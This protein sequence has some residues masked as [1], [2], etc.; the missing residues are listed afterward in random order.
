VLPDVNVWLA[1][2]FQVHAHHRAAVEWF[3]EADA[4]SCHWCRLTQQGFLRLATN[5]SVFGDEA[6]TLM[7]AWSCFDTFM[8][9][10]RVGFDPEPPGIESVWRKHTARREYSPRVWNDAYLAG[11][12]TTAGLTLVTFDRGF[13]QY[14]DLNVHVLHA[15]R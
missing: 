12:A 14:E 8:S 13:V 11:F 7:E 10:E 15:S 5:Q 9:D 3:D 1:L 6:I 4:G 2:A